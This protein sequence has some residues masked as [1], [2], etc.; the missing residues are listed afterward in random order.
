MDGFAI[1]SSADRNPPWAW[2]Q[3]FPG[4][5]GAEGLL[6]DP[7]RRVTWGLG[8]ALAWRV[9]GEYSSRAGV[10]YL[11]DLARGEFGSSESSR[12]LAA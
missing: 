6:D 2:A 7:L 10:L 5:R 4:F 9:P 1:T 8:G 3:A 11:L 12:D